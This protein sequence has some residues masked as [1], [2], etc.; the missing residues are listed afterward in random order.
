MKPNPHCD[1]PSALL[2]TQNDSFVHR[3]GDKLELR[4][5]DE[6][7]ETG[8]SGD[9]GH[10]VCDSECID[11]T[12]RFLNEEV[13]GWGH[14]SSPNQSNEYVRTEECLDDVHR[15]VRQLEIHSP[16]AQAVST[17]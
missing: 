8:T 14:A 6:N 17:E 12:P 10:L 13:C 15:S 5:V 4:T 7:L 3:R 2:L 9:P 11:R 16:A 1:R